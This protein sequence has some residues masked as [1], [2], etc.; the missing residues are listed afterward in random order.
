MSFHVGSHRR[1]LNSQV[2][3]LILQVLIPRVV[4]GLTFQLRPFFFLSIMSKISAARGSVR[5]P[6]YKHSQWALGNVWR[7]S[8]P[9]YFLLT[10]TNLRAENSELL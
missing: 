1:R 9:T 8:A 3:D 10:G 4:L 5:C 6:V 2:P 7:A